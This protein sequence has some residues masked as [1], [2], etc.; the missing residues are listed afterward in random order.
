MLGTAC[1]QCS[2][3]LGL[4]RAP[5]TLWYGRLSRPLSDTLAALSSVIL[6][7]AA[8]RAVGSHLGAVVRRLLSAL[9]RPRDAREL[10]V[11]SA[12]A[13]V[14]ARPRR[15]CSC[16]T[17]NSLLVVGAGEYTSTAELT[18]NADRSNRQIQPSLLVQHCC[19]CQ[20][21][22]VARSPCAWTDAVAQTRSTCEHGATKCAARYGMGRLLVSARVRVCVCCTELPTFLLLLLLSH[23]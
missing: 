21:T 14:I 3:R 7:W 9:L 17:S 2:I 19:E 16:N 15:R 1:P 23:R 13:Q 4:Y 22:V 10:E 18:R 8:N 12:G 6:L 11:G 5:T 20:T